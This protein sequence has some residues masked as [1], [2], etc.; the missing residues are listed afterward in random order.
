MFPLALVNE[1]FFFRRI[2]TTR[3]L[4]GNHCELH[5]CLQRP[6]PPAAKDLDRNPLLT[7]LLDIGGS[8]SSAHSVS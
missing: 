7:L 6:Q 8:I 4:R 3:W 5:E 2:Y 1:K